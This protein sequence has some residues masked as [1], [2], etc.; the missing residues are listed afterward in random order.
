MEKRLS[1]QTVIVTGAGRGIGR[2]I[3][4]GCAKAGAEIALAS[5]TESE[6]QETAEEV[7]SV[8][9][10]AL[11]VPTDVTQQDQVDHL[12]K[13]TINRLGPVDLLINNA[14]RLAEPGPMW[15][16]D[17]DDWLKDILVNIF[18][19]FLC[20]KAVL[21]NMI[22]RGEGRIVNI[23]GGGVTGAFE[24]ASSYGCS[25]AAVMRLTETIAEELKATG[26][27]VKVFAL[28]P[29]LVPTEMTESF[30]TTEAGRK[31][32]SG[33]AER[34]EKGDHAPPEWAAEMIV[35][36]ASGGLDDLHGRF[37]T[38]ERDREN[39]DELRQRIPEIIEQDLRTLRI[40]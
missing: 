4:V 13:E 34:L 15:E 37:L 36:I 14:G 18:G 26:A 1:G 31:W 40:R 27:A 30:K 32:M 12:A 20:S 8:G 35:E 23:V 24:Y 10:S 2:A 39:I 6:L 16:A 3:A 19:V 11:V 25:K 5:R 29:G 21:P 38:S 17:P 7:R 33:L 28:T 22:E 9:G